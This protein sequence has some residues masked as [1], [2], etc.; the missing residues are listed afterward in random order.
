MQ[1]ADAILHQMRQV[2]FGENVDSI[3]TAWLLREWEL[4]S[5]SNPTA[6]AVSAEEIFRFDAICVT[7]DHV[8]EGADDTFV[9]VKVLERDVFCVKPATESIVSGVS[10]KNWFQL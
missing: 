5:F 2:Y 6:S 7:G 9:V 1:V 3:T 8:S 4:Q 10:G